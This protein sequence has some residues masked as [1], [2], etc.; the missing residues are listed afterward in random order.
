MS[1]PK[2]FISCDWG[3]TNFRLKLVETDSL[4]VVE[5]YKT[6]QGVKAV[7]EK[8]LAQKAMDQRQFY[9]HYLIEQIKELPTE[10]QHHPVVAAG[11]ASSNMGL[12]ELAYGIFPF[13]S[14]G[15]QLL[16]KRIPLREKQDMLLISGVK[17]NSGMMRGEEVQAIGLGENLGA[18]SE[19]VLLLPGTHSKHIAFKQGIFQDLTTYLTGELFEVLIKRSI[20]SSSVIPGE[21]SKE[22]EAA[23]HEGL[24][25]GLK[26]RL[27]ANLFSVRARDIIGKYKK[28]DNYFYLSGMLIGD[29]ISYLKNYKGKV[30]LAA[31]APLFSLYQMGLE[32]WLSSQQ[33]SLFNG[34]MLEGALLKGQ[35][36]ILKI[37]GK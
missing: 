14:S 36:K 7:Y 28:E 23:F 26:G 33:L 6:D 10:H 8:F 25:V 19:G 3:T 1:L 5:E 32:T 20:L 31:P 24:Q 17:G 9:S 15:E 27:M 12:C 16:C 13:D 29:E 2:Y 34:A 30:F 18:Y 35:R 21:W 11:M 22:S 37:H 4:K